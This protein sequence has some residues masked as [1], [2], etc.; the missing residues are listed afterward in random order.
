[1]AVR[2]S[3]FSFW[4]KADQLRLR[5]RPLSTK[6][7]DQTRLLNTT[8]VFSNESAKERV[9]IRHSCFFVNAPCITELS[10]L[11]CTCSIC[12]FGVWCISTTD[13]HHHDS[14]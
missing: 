6:K 14:N 10:K 3:I 11:Q 2:S 13:G 1:F 9:R 4:E 5:L 7:P 12:T 8:F